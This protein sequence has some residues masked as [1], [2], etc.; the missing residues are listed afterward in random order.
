MCCSY[1]VYDI[2]DFLLISCSSSFKL[3]FVQV[4]R[5]FIYWLSSHSLQWALVVSLPLLVIAQMF[6][7][8]IECWNTVLFIPQSL[9]R[10]LIHEI[11][12]VFYL[13]V[14][15]PGTIFLLI[16]AGY[17]E[18]LW[19][20]IYIIINMAFIFLLRLLFNHRN[21]QRLP[22]VAILN[23]WLEN[24]LLS[25]HQWQRWSNDVTWSLFS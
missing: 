9:H 20:L 8:I 12:N 5:I 4:S 22:F 7:W 11:W 10:F 2:I 1:F 23:R 24:L 21:I 16:K 6:F 17:F 14:V 19:H 3:V 18:V 13:A 25:S 15:V